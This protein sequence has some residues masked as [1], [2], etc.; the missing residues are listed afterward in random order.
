TNW[1]HYK[2]RSGDTLASLSKKYHTNINSIRRM[3]QLTSVHLK[4]GTNL[5]IPNKSHTR[6]AE[7]IED[8]KFERQ[9]LAIKNPTI[10]TKSKK[11]LVANHKS[12]NINELVLPIYS[13]L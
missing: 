6:S 11:T 8:A 7:E 4:P 5:L 13:I 10:N 2:V 3:N 9:L 1:L 12:K